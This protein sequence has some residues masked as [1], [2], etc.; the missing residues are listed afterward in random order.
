MVLDHV[1]QRASVLVIAA[2]MTHANCLRHRDR[3]LIHIPPVPD[4]LE[5]RVA[6][7]EG[8]NV[9]HCFFSQI[10]VDAKNL[11][12]VKTLGQVV[13]QLPCRGKV[14]SDGFLHHDAVAQT[15]LSQSR[16]AEQR[17]ND[18]H[19]LGRRGEVKNV[20]GTAPPVFVQ[21]RAL[22]RQ[23]GVG[24]RVFEVS[25]LIRQ[26]APFKFPLRAN[27]FTPSS[28]RWRNAPSC[29]GIRSTA[30]MAKCAGNRP[31]R[32]K[33]NSDGISLRQVRSPPPPKITRTVGE[34]CMRSYSFSHWV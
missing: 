17:R 23:G 32:C 9:L 20:T 6:E 27:F 30:I 18:P 11:R 19:H 12:L 26:S 8:E 21:F 22:C 28:K 5:E 13:I 14:M 31:A 2:P 24:G 7:A 10:V 15:V 33:S 25:L 4:R 29:M 3:D 34:I 1:A 16:I